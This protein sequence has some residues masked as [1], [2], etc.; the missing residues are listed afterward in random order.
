VVVAVIAGIV[1]I[2]ASGSKGSGSAGSASSEEQKYIGRLLPANY[3]EPKVA[4][5]QIYA[6]T[7][8]MTNLTG[9]QTAAGISIPVDQLV[10]DKIALFE[11]KKPGADAIPLIAYIKPS[12][13]LFVGV[14]YCPPCE[15][16]GQ[17]IEAG[18]TLVCETCGTVRTLESGVGVSGACKLYPLDE[19]S[20]TVADGKISVATSALDSWTPQPLDRPT[21]S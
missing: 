11:Y 19:L 2:S 17:R 5:P 3:S 21:G 9:T 4:D 7:V 1:A 18:G 15:G 13:K 16:K 20:A 10:A 6:T 14:S 8:K 12:G